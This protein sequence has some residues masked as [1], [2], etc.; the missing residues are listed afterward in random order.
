VTDLQKT[1][2]LA[3]E[4]LVQARI[5]QAKYY[6]RGQ[7]DAPVFEKGDEIL[8]LRKFIQTQRV[9]SK[10]DYR[11]LGPFRVVEMVGK[12]TVRLDIEKDFPQLHPVFNVS[13]TVKYH[14]PNSLID[15]GRNTGIKERYF[16]QNDVVD[17]L[18]LKQVLDVRQVKKKY[19]YL[20][21]WK[22]VTVGDDTWV[23][24][25]HIPDRLTSYLIQ[26]RKMHKELYEKTT[27]KNSKNKKVNTDSEVALVRFTTC[28]FQL[29]GIYDPLLV[30]VYFMHGCSAC[31]ASKLA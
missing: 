2:E 7:S 28:W 4:C 23:A 13:L 10:L 17:W 20:L 22:N 31:C 15:R 30:F 24:E 27:K 5:L 21:L 18:K 25:N 26:F 29:A 12:N 19:E 1:Q 9:N 3:I 14:D 6:N 11:Y 16:R 8:L